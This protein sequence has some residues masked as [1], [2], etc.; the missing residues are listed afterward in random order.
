MS[1]AR[2][3]QRSQGAATTCASRCLCISRS[4]AR[5][6]R[7]S[8]TSTTATSAWAG[9]S[10]S[11]AWR[12]WRATASPTIS[13][14]TSSTSDGTTSTACSTATRPS[15]S[16]FSQRRSSNSWRGSISIPTYC[17][18]T[19]GRRAWPRRSSRRSTRTYPNTR[20]S[21]R[22]SRSTTC[23]SRACSTAASRTSC[24]PSAPSRSTPTRLNTAGASAT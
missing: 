20:G 6:A 13:W 21:G 16:A 10:S 1:R 18:S 17:T 22:F 23:A 19:T 5:T 15:A 24:S 7:S 9:A 14:T 11:S 12:A 2:C 3:P 4:A 8:S